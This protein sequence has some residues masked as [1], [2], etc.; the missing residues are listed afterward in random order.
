MND[1]WQKIDEL[2]NEAVELP[3]SERAAFLAR[4]CGS[5]EGLRIEVESLLSE[6][7][8]AAE[9]QTRLPGE[10]LA[11]TRSTALV[12]RGQQ[13]GGYT[14]LSLLGE[15]G[16]GQ[17][18][19]AQDIKLGRRVALKILPAQFTRDSLRLRRFRHEARAI[20]SLNHPN[21]ITIYEIGHTDDLHYIVT[22]FIEGQTLRKLL[23]AR[24]LG[25]VEALGIACQIGDALA[26]AH[27]A[28]IIH[29]DI[30]PENVMVR[31]D[32]YVKVLDFGL[33]KQTRKATLGEA[34]DAVSTIS[35]VN[36]DPGAVMGTVRYMSPEQARGLEV[37]ARSD[38]FSLGVVLYE[39]LT[40][41]MPFTGQTNSDVLAAILSSEPPPLARFLPNAPRELQ[42]MLNKALRKDRD[43]RYQTVR[44]MLAD[45]RELRQD[46]DARDRLAR[47]TGSNDPY[48]NS[49]EFQPTIS[50]PPER[51]ERSER[52]SK[53]PK[54]DET[55]GKPTETGQSRRTG[56]SP[57]VRNTGGTGRIAALGAALAVVVALGFGGYRWL[58]TRRAPTFSVENIR[59]MKL[60]TGVTADASSISPDGKY[61][62]YVT[63][64]G[65][66][67]IWVR[68]VATGST[69]KIAGP[70]DVAMWGLTFSPDGNYLYYVCEPRDI[71]VGGILYQVPSLGGTP[72]EVTRKIDGPVTFSPDGNRMVFRRYNVTPG[73]QAILTSRIDGSDEKTVATESMAKRLF[74]TIQWL[75]DDRG[76]LMVNRET[77]G[78]KQYFSV[79]TL[80]FGG[81]GEQTLV[82]RQSAV[83]VSAWTP[84]GTALFLNARDPQNNQLQLWYRPT[85]DAEFRRITNDLNEYFGLSVT[86]DGS[87]LATMQWDKMANLFVF[88]LDGPS[89][90]LRQVIQGAAWYECGEWGTSGDLLYTVVAGGKAAIWS[91]SPDG[92]RRTPLTETG[93]NF[94]PALSPDGK[95]IAFTS[96]RSGRDE[97]W[98]MNADGNAPRQVT[99]NGGTG[100]RWSPDGASII[101]SHY[102][103]G[104]WG[105][106]RVPVAGG[107]PQSLTDDTIDAS[108]PSI[109]PDGKLLAYE[110]NEKGK[111]SRL[112]IRPIA[113][114]APT[115]E[116]QMKE[117]IANVPNWTP[118][119]QN[120]I[121]CDTQRVWRQPLRPNAPAEM[122]LEIK[123]EKIYWAALSRDG[124]KVV[125]TKGNPIS[126]IILL[127]NRPASVR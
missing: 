61:L 12:E 85:P 78:E 17:V 59:L 43:A 1:R 112:I 33:A 7:D 14:I 100:P 13:L 88:N 82:P 87:S 22:E 103:G 106:W 65:G 53:A 46:L 74:R 73:V 8:E 18:W 47:T 29:R 64:E 72:R 92:A 86:A 20:V 23:K 60:T 36:T 125:V 3:A 97:I 27:G 50:L 38:I 26:S 25:V 89:R 109:S 94:Y 91:A 69:V 51:S 42:W 19:L 107:S 34:F 66:T 98:V 75:P 28:R 93:R 79:T 55:V 21:I 124:K 127:T 116:F 90:E 76:L 44:E 117:G 70:L 122:L 63:Y 118:D 52:S 119:G 108:S 99:N 49:D 10:E 30:K 58:A 115:M 54:T 121:Y 31:P 111:P 123:T 95:T 126:D 67:V 15:G 2:F 56:A 9:R 113:G 114:G 39:M 11:E 45:L 104:G 71:P 57:T 5:D 105:V 96:N 81:G 68:Q 35:A 48:Q 83:I 80:P 37:D 102:R 6:D 4:A 16:M 110:V 77:E 62:A 32:G 84:D 40:G 41:R 101:Y 24:E 120:L